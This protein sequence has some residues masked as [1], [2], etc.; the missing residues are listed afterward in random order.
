MRALQL[1]GP[2]RVLCDDG[3]AVPRSPRRRAG[4]AEHPPDQDHLW[5]FRVSAGH[6]AAGIVG[7]IITVLE[8]IFLL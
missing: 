5:T 6:A 2:P 3:D 4:R 7:I 1:R 8:V